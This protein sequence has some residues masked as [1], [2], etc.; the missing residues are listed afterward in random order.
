MDQGFER[1]HLLLL[2]REGLS[3]LVQLCSQLPVLRC[4]LL[5][6]ERIGLKPVAED[7]WRVYFAAFPIAYFNSREFQVGPCGLGNDEEE[8]NL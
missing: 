3:G 5:G 6:G 2:P 1:G 8:A 7:G 4:E